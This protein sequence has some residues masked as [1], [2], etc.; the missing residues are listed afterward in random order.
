MNKFY[1]LTEIGFDTTKETKSSLIK[2][3]EQHCSAF[4]ERSYY[5][6]IDTL[7]K[8]ICYLTDN[9][10]EIVEYTIT[11]EAVLLTNTYKKQPKTYTVTFINCDIPLPEISASSAEEVRK[12]V[13]E[14]VTEYLKKYNNRIYLNG[15]TYVS[16]IKNNLKNELLFYI[17]PLEQIQKD[18]EKEFNLDSNNTDWYDLIEGHYTEEMDI[19]TGKIYKVKEIHKSG[20]AYYVEGNDWL[21]DKRLGDLFE[22]VYNNNDTIVLEKIN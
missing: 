10:F 6:P 16:K 19:H 8:A 18:M 5:H 15:T 3:A 14:K 21:W 12:I 9:G 20:N 4:T 22:I 17:H 2:I 1:E 11:D 7:D 13:K